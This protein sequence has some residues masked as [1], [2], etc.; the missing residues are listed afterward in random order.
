MLPRGFPLAERGWAI[1]DKKENLT[2]E[3]ARE[4]IDEVEHWYHRIEVAPGVVTP[5]VHDSEAALAAMELPERLDGKRLLDVGARDGYFSFV[6]EERGAEI[7]AID[8]MAPHLTG[9]ATASSLL[10]AS[11]E[12]RTMNVYNVCPEN[13]GTFDVILFL[14]VLYHLRDPML[15]L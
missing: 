7:L 4:A 9:F 13:V 12:Y 14:G 5:G 2:P 15:A 6:A 10:G 11:V 1:I 3:E 8:S